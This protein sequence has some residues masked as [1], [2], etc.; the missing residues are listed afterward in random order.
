MNILLLGNGFD[1]YHELPTK[2]HNF[3]NI[4]DY[5]IKN[6]H[7]KFNYIGDILAEKELQSKDKYIKR[8]YDAHS[9]IYNEVESDQEMIKELIAL[10]KDNVWFSY[11]MKSFNVDVGWI[12]FEKE[13]AHVLSAFHK[14]LVK[15]PAT[16]SLAV[17]FEK[18]GNNEPDLKYIMKCFDFFYK[19][20]SDAAIMTSTYYRTYDEYCI[21]YPLHSGNIIIN[22]EKVV[23]VLVA[24]IKKLSK[25]L[26]LYLSIFVESILSLMKEKADYKV[27]GAIS[28]I[29]HTI[30]L[31][32]TNS[33]ERL[34]G[35]NPVN[36]LH[37]KI[38]N[39]I[40]L[41]VNPDDSDNKDTV[42]T[43]LLAFKKYY[44]RSIAETDRAFWDIIAEA[45]NKLSTVQLVI[46]GH[47][48]DVTDKDVIEQLFAVANSIDILFHDEDAKAQY[49]KNLVRIFG[50]DG[51][52]ALRRDKDLNFLHLD[53]DF[54][55]F[56]K[57]LY[58]TSDL[59]ELER[60]K[61]AYKEVPVIV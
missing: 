47:S 34:Y 27:C 53:S 24:E 58:Q 26:K 37:G 1:I 5:L 42:N 30:N 11:F 54:S 9:T 10:C 25:A 60:L 19:E 2:Y 14:F 56:R 31:N 4:V 57:C 28:D 43:L 35:S 46:M 51:F 38:D 36:Y 6:D 61:K 16:F 50:K 17:L 15:A 21:E 20:H 52:E 39:E 55:E 40:V 12:D 41:G 45:D 29:D 18:N 48:L 22:K 13:M 49:I 7:S 23:D 44:Q 59:R 8:C 33:Y 32:Y 3:L